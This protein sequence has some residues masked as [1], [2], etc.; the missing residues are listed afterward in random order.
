[1]LDN[2]KDRAGS[3]YDPLLLKTPA[4]TD[5]TP[6]PQKSVW[7]A[8]YPEMNYIK[9]LSQRQL[10]DHF[11]QAFDSR[12]R[13]PDYNVTSSYQIMIL[14]DVTTKFNRTMRAGG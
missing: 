13:N 9:K 4:C 11:H 6:P 14:F 8:L 10:T 5:G 12:G 2:L 1:M 3:F 7:H